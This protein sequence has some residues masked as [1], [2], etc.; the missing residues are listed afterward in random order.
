MVLGA[1]SVRRLSCLLV[2]CLVTNFFPS[3]LL[4]AP[5][6]SDDSAEVSSTA[7]PS[8]ERPMWNTI[9]RGF[10]AF[11]VTTGIKGIFGM[12]PG[13]L[14]SLIPA[15]SPAFAIPVLV[16]AGLLEGVIS[17][18]AISAI[19]GMKDRENLVRSFLVASVV[20]SS[21]HFFLAGFLAPFQ[22][23]L[24]ASVLRLGLFW[25]LTKPEHETLEQHLVAEVKSAVGQGSDD[26]TTSPPT[27]Q[28][29]GIAEVEQL[30]RLA[31]NNYLAATEDSSREEAYERFHYYTRL[32][33]ELRQTHSEQESVGG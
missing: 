25:I 12:A 11:A 30:R 29:L 2:C 27:S 5:P 7:S 4:A 14:A 19:L 3:T 33:G 26:V 8:K 16:G 9:L 20:A 22:L 31:Y 21:T 28:N 18:G 23:N 24:L 15:F 17:F 6:I 10:A 13:Y 1:R 32:L